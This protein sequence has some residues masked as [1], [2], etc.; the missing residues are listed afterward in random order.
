MT[1]ENMNNIKKICTYCELFNDGIDDI[2]LCCLFFLAANGF[3]TFGFINLYAYTFNFYKSNLFI[4]SYYNSF[5]FS[6]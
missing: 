2:S 6:S 4:A 5:F 1:I 3:Y